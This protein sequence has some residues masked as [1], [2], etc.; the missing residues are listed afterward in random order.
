MFTGIIETTGII[1]DISTNGNNKTFVVESSIS[2]S[3]KTDQS[4]AHNGICLTVESV[5]NNTHTITA[6]HE[7]LQKTNTNNWQLNELINIERCLIANGRVDGHF[8]QGH[9]DDVATCINIKD[10]AGSFIYT[11]AF[12]K[13][14]AALIIEKGSVCINGISLTC[15]NVTNT[16]FNVAIIP[17]TFH[18]TN[19]KNLAINSTV[20]IEFDVLGK[21]INRTLQ[22]NAK[23]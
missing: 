18:H 22:L 17:Y 23:I 7:T 8:V 2:N 1:K 19:I 14:F 15:F 13:K 9:V 5:R 4:V 21:Y 16:Q 3:L 12:N 10:D 11:F 6:V 20:N